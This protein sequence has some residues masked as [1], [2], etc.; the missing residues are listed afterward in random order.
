MENKIQN[1][2][3]PQWLIEEMIAF[4]YSK[5]AVLKTKDLKS[6]LHVPIVPLP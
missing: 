2:N 5:G 1:F 3:L 4:L 6:V